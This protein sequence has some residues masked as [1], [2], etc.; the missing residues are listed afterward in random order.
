MP[1]ALSDAQLDAI[2]AAA[3]PL[4]VRDRDG[5]LQ[6]VA[7]QLHGRRDL[8]DGDVDRAIR[9]VQRRF[10]DPPLSVHRRIG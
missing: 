9:A 7:E 10:F 6:A 4:A 8:G 3:R 1:I 2:F 5:F